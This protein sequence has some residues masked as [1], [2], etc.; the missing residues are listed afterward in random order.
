M[1]DIRHGEPSDDARPDHHSDHHTD[2]HTGAH[3]DA[4][5]DVAPA[6]AVDPQ[7]VV[8]DAVRREIVAGELAPGQ[9]LVEIEL[10]QR[11]H[12]SRNAARLAL[13]ELAHDGLVERIPNR[14]ARV[15]AVSVDEAIEITEV[16]MVVEGL[17]AAKAA[18]RI[19]DAEVTELRDLGRAMRDA[20]AT[21]EVLQYSKLN[22]RLHR[23]IR[24]IADQ[25]TA[26]DVLNRLR[27]QNVRHQF[28]LA[29][30]PG[31]PR[32]SLVEHLAVI[33]EV[34]ARA[35]D[36]AERAMRRHLASVIDALRTTPTGD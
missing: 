30:R 22:E 23:R 35:P 18:E 27:A 26:Q 15:R 1:P 31:R 8:V 13:V 10:S 34:C 25:R 4:L 6:T 11:Y 29:L 32:V 14:G 33:D 20:V 12:V 16:R 24:E 17:C 28:Q 5:R 2:H 36:A 7:V 9:R 21:G 19:T 3:P